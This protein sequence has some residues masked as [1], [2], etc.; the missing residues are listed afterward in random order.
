M[1]AFLKDFSDW[2]HADGYRG[3]CKLSKNIRK[4][5][6]WTSAR[7]KFDEVLQ[8]QMPPNE[9]RQDSLVAT[10]ECYCTSLSRL[11]ELIVGLTAEERY[12]KRLELVK[13]WR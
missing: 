13:N 12:A 10:R 9:R 5:A 1:E 7:Q 4:A 2:L 8:A 11:E 6:R 3:H